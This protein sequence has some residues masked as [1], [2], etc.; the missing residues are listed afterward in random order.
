MERIAV[1]GIGRIGLCLA[2]NLER[3][4]YEVLGVD[5]DREH[6]KRVSEKTYRTSEPAV[7]NALVAARSF[8]AVDNIGAIP[9]FNPALFLSRLLRPRPR[10]E[11]MTT[12]ASIVSSLISSRSDQRVNELNSY[13][14]ARRCPAIAIRRRT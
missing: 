12:V 1:I 11:P 8:R 9:D 10:L 13:W 7:E 2:L 4:G 14:F 6:V 3:A 5:A